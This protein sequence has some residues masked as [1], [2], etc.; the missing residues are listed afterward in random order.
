[1][2]CIRKEQHKTR[3][4]RNRRTSK[5]KKEGERATKTRIK[6]KR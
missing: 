3:M 1:M 6:E 2:I 4:R 5:R